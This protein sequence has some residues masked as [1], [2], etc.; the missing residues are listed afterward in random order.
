MPELH[1]TPPAQSEWA[2]TAEE[3]ERM[4]LALDPDATHELHGPQ[5]REYAICLA[6][7]HGYHDSLEPHA[8]C[9]CACHQ[10]ALE[11]PRKQTDLREFYTDPISFGLKL[12]GVR[13]AA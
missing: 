5:N 9:A 6:C 12:V 13:R 11:T 10:P 2:P 4:F 7:A 3:M 8:D 1:R